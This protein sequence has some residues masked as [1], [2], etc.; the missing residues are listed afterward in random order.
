MF[1][2]DDWH[3]TRRLTVNYGLRWE[4]EFSPR[5]PIPN[6]LFPQS[7]VMPNDNKG[8]G[9]R[10]GLA[11]DI[12][13]TGKTVLRGGGG[14]YYGRIINEQIYGAISQDGA[15][16]SQIAQTIFPTTGSTNSSGTL[17]PGAP[18]YPLINTLFNGGAGQPSIVYF[19]PNARMPQIDQYDAVL[20]HE[21]APNTVVSVSYIGAYGRF[22]PMGIDTN[23]PA[24]VG[25][26]TYTLAGTL[27]TA[28]NN[29]TIVGQLPAVGSTFTVPFYPGGTAARPNHNFQTMAELSTSAKSWYNAGVVQLT[30][31]MQHGLQVQTSY[32][33]AH[34]IDTDQQSSALIS[35]S[36]PLSPCQH[37]AG[38]RQ[39]NL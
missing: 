10:A 20:E 30:R 38:S 26:I 3:L 12:F 31:R 33:W 4:K 1:F 13:G 32:T 15:P 14:I 5:N 9:P 29:A 23:A 19:A 28:G 16:Q 2:Q 17:T 8:I 18:I 34:A 39:F 36:T 24:Q 35:S 25:T 22:L 7:G 11:W 6:P 27:P 37:R 21:I